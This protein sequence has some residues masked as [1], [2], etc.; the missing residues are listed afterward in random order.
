MKIKTNDRMV[1]HTVSL[2]RRQADAVQKDAERLGISFGD[3]LRR[4]LDEW[5]DKASP[6]LGQKLYQQAPR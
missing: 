2:T 3:R 4:I 6:G 5:T 1:P